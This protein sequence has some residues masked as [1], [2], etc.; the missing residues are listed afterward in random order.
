M[1]IP[2]H[3]ASAAR[4]QRLSHPGHLS[5]WAYLEE[6]TRAYAR[7][8]ARSKVRAHLRLTT[9][10]GTDELLF[11]EA[12]LRV[13]GRTWVRVRL[14]VRPTGV[15]GWVPE[16]RLGAFQEVHT[17]LVVN[18]RTLRATLYRNGRRIFR[19][20]V[21]VGKPGT[22][23]PAGRF[24]V[25]S[26]LTGFGPSSMYGPLA[27]GT[28]A[29]S[30]VLTDWPGGGYIGIHGTSWPSLVPGRPSH[31]CI[32]MHNADIL[33]LGRLMGVGTPVTII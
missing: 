9:N 24:Y 32:R 26:R 13:A 12:S 2:A 15:T 8:T 19:A 29:A 5:R 25:R 16:D 11:L 7:P 14:P 18:R 20:P 27:F 3:P 6:A 33:R 21:G 10:D 31:G 1:T 30:R 17:H 4:V 22:P 23:T 28:S